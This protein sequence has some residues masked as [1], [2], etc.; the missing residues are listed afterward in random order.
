MP[1]SLQITLAPSDYAHA[2]ELLPHQVRTWQKQVDE[3][4]ITIDFHRSRG[5]FSARWLDGEKK[6]R[7][8]AESIAGA[9]VVD[10]DYSDAARR[11]VSAAFFGGARLPQKDFRGGPYYS[12]F[13]GMAEA[14]HDLVLHTDSDMFFG[15]GSQTWI[16]EAT[17]LLAAHPQVLFTAPLPGPPHPDGRLVQL[18]SRIVAGP[19]H[20]HE[21][22]EM[23]TRLF[24]F[25]RARFQ[26]RIGRLVPRR[27]PFKNAVIALLEGNSPRDLPEHLFTDAM[28][29]HGLVRREF[30]GRAPGMW[31]L[32]PPYRG[33]DFYAKLPVLVR[34]VE[35]GDLPDAQR[36]DHDLNDSLVDWSEGR[37]A[38]RQNRIWRR[39]WRRWFG[40]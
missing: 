9:R 23:S 32:H 35:S 21:F 7:P 34:R 31:S 39:V 25:S 2:R 33:A 30:L 26:E 14:K 1:V 15:G 20:V 8:L 11:R 5:R 6:I 37:M 16:E 18:R 29:E 10:V 40:G 36:G 22:P 19:P 3:I 12:Y 17:A 4:L 38:L 28:R 24:L 27:A 13:F